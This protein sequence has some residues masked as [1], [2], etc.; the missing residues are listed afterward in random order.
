M[1]ESMREMPADVIDQRL[2]ELKSYV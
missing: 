1:P 2:A